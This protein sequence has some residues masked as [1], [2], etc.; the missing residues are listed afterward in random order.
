MVTSMQSMAEGQSEE[1]TRGADQ[2]VADITILIRQIG[3]VLLSVLT[4]CQVMPCVLFI[5]RARKIREINWVPK[6]IMVLASID[7]LTWSSNYVLT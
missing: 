7:G 3:A 5:W 6:T 4:V 1:T 2:R